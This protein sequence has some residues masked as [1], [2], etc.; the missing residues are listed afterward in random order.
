MLHTL[1]WWAT[2]GAWFVSSTLLWVQLLIFYGHFYPQATSA[3][4]VLSW[5]GSSVCLSACPSPSGLLQTT[6]LHKIAFLTTYL[7]KYSRCH[8]AHPWGW[9]MGY[10]LLVQSL[11][12]VLSLSLSWCMQYHMLNCLIMEVV[13]TLFLA[14]SA[15]N[16][17]CTVTS[18][19]KMWINPFHK[20]YNALDKCPIMHHFVTEMCTPVHISVT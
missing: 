14:V 1:P 17:L 13:V 7:T 16:M 18:I 19:T 12:Y 20:S 3:E 9:D 6:I 2:C 4:G 8:I 10:L 15:L 5:L 11:I